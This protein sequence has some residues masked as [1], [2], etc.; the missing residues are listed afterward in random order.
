[1]VL[2]YE[3]LEQAMSL[4]TALLSWQVEIVNPATP[5]SFSIKE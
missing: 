2:S 5:S 3:A 1:M 4:I